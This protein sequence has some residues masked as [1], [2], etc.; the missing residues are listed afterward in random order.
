MNATSFGPDDGSAVRGRLVEAFV[1]F[2]DIQEASAERAAR[3][4]AACLLRVR[5]AV[6]TPPDDV[7]LG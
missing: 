4:G 5:A 7:P 6:R 2:V 1:R 3:A